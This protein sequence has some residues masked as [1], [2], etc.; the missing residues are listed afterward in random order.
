MKNRLRE[1]LHVLVHRAGHVHQAEHHGLRD[2]RGTRLE[3]AAI[4]H[5][6]RVDEGDQ[7]MRFA[8]AL[9]PAVSA[10]RRQQL[11]SGSAIGSQLPPARAS[12]A[13]I[14]SGLRPVQCDAPRNSGVTHGAHHRQRRG[15]A[16]RADSRRAARLGLLDTHHLALG[17]GLGSSRSSR[18]RSQ[19]LVMPTGRSGNRLRPRRRRA[20]RQRPPPP[21]PSSGRGMVSPSMYF[22]LP[23]STYSRLPPWLPRRSAGSRTP[24]AGTTMS[25]PCCR[26]RLIARVRPKPSRT[27]RR[28][29][30]RAP[31]EKSLAVRRATCLRDHDAGR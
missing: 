1:V 6:D 11:A 12:S 17:T 22:L 24:S 30:A 7:P 28:T 15:R 25:P 23:G 29:R 4:A 27:A 9:E 26:R 19:E 16:R 13:A 18:N 20:G 14:S 5:V 31:A 10:P 3:L 2:R 8:L 21:P